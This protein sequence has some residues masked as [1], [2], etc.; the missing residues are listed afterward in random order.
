MPDK[1]LTPEEHIGQAM[2]HIN[3][4]YYAAKK[5]GIVPVL[6]S[7]DYNHAVRILSVLKRRM[8]GREDA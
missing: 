3:L 6:V 1:V 5:A 2:Q 4:A 7:E 8:R